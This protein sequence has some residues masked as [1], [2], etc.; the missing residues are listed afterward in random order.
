MRSTPPSPDS[1]S[2]PTSSDRAIGRVEILLSAIG[3]GFIGIFGKRAFAAG[4]APGEYLTMRFALAAGLLWCFALVARR[5]ELR[6]TRRQLA[7]CA[8][9]GVFGYALF[10]T[11]YFHA[12][13][14]LSASLTSLLL[15]TFPVI[16]TIAAWALFK[17][18]IGWRR[19]LALPV[20]SAGLVLLLWGDLAVTDWGAVGLAL[21]SAL[22]YSTYILASSRL[23]HGMDSLVAGLYIMTAAAVAL[24]V[25][26]APSPQ[27]IASL[28]RPAW[29][30]IVG[31]ALVSTLAPLVLFLRGLKRLTNAEASILSLLEPVTTVVAAAALLGERLAPVQIAGGALVIVALALSSLGKR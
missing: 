28:D 8:A 4:L 31:I 10:T 12:L 7:A 1:T 17:E 3:Y 30:A 26:D 27:L 18:P 16:V 13:R 19:G 2:N 21:L 6:V 9:L 20:V 24:A 14:G 25:V 11:L 22:F 15:Y 29:N 5:A 23:L